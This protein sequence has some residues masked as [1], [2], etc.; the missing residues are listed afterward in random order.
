M[1]FSLLQRTSSLLWNALQDSMTILSAIWGWWWKWYNI[2][3]LHMTISAVYVCH[4][5]SSKVCYHISCM[6]DGCSNLRMQD[7]RPLNFCIEPDIQVIKTA[8]TYCVIWPH[9]WLHSSRVRC[10]LTDSWSWL[11]CP[12]CVIFSVSH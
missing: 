12:N 7:N 3:W 8:L 4:F 2:S 11:G 1:L 9:S 5:S 6:Y 10:E